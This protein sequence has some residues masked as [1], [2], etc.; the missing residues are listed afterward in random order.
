MALCVHL[1]KYKQLATEQAPRA[2]DHFATW[3][4]SIESPPID[5]AINLNSPVEVKR[6]RQVR[7]HHDISQVPAAS[8]EKL[9]SWR[10]AQHAA[11]LPYCS[12]FE[13]HTD[14]RRSASGKSYRRI[15]QPHSLLPQLGHQ[16]LR[17]ALV[18][19]ASAAGA[20]PRRYRPSVRHLCR[21]SALLSGLQSEVVPRSRERLRG[22]GSW[23]LI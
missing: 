6:L 17:E 19:S 9:H 1:Q 8:V 21:R 13:R 12:P 15:A 16:P 10:L 14:C 18:P 23:R 4:Q 22:L 3:R 20:K 2:M 11:R 7:Y 5:S